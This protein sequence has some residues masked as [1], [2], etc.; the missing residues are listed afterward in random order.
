MDE[1]V[2]QSVVNKFLPY[3]GGLAGA[4]LLGE[5]TRIYFTYKQYKLME[6]IEANTR[7]G[8]QK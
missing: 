3:V 4:L 8:E 2:I 1:Y 5:A 7:H 6:K